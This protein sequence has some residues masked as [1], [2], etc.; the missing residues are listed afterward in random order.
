MNIAAFGLEVKISSTYYFTRNVL[1]LRDNNMFYMLRQVGEWNWILPLHIF[2][3][4]SRMY[5]NF[6]FHLIAEHSHLQILNV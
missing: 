5:F 2:A 1:N 4:H 3:S 6:F